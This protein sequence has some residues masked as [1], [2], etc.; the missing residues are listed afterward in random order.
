MWLYRSLFI[1]LLL[2]IRV[3][4]SLREGSWKQVYLL[5]ASQQHQSSSAPL[6]HEVGPQ[7]FCQALSFPYEH[8]MESCRK[9]LGNGYLEPLCRRSPWVLNSHVNHTHPWRVCQH[10]IVFIPAFMPVISPSPLC[11]IPPL[12]WWAPYPLE[13]S[14]SDWWQSE[15][16][17]GLLKSYDFWDYPDFSHH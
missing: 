13:F 14:S 4:S 10:F 9:D 3:G 2:D 7:G 17:D 15:T 8:L 6:R 5:P 1:S 16:S 12:L 11:C